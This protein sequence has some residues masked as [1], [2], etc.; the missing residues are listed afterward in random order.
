[1]KKFVNTFTAII[2]LIISNLPTTL[3]ADEIYTYNVTTNLSEISVTETERGAIY[4]FEPDN[5]TD[6]SGAPEIPFKIIRLALPPNTKISS[7]TANG[8]RIN[9]IAHNLDYAWNEGEMKT[10]IDATYDPAPK[11]MAIYNSS[12][13]YP[14]KYIELLNYGVMGAQPL[15]CFAIYPIQYRPIDGELMMVG[16]INI[17]I[18]LNS[19]LL[20][21][22]GP[23]PEAINIV[24]Q[25]VNNPEG[26][27]IQAPSLTSGDGTIPGGTIMGIGAEYLIITSGELAPAFYPFAVWKNQKGLLTEIVLIE[28]VLARYSGEDDAA[29]LREYLKEAHLAGAKW[30]LLGGDEDIIPI[31]Y[32]YPGNVNSAPELKNQQVSDLYFADL[33]GNWDVDGDGT[34]GEYVH[35]QPDIYPEVYVGR[36][37]AVS[38][39]EV[40]IWVNKA[41]MYEQNP[42]N[43]DYDYL[44]RGLFIINDQMRDLNQH[45]ELAGL[46]PDNFYVDNSSCAEEP[47]GG[48][49]EPTQPSGE[50]IV[51]AM[52]QGWGYISNHNHGGFYYYAARTPG[53]NNS[54]RSDMYGDTI[55]YTEQAGA[56]SHLDESNKYGVHY[57]ISCYN[58]AY[59]FDKEVFWPGPFIT[60]NSFMEAFLFLPEKGGV[61]YLGNTRWG[62]VSSSS[63]LEKKFVEYVFSDTAR[64]LAVA[65]TLSK[66]YYPTK[67]DLGYG[68][69]L[70][71]DPEMRIWA[72]APIL[73]NSSVPEHISLDSTS[74]TVEVSTAGG[75]AANIN[76]TAWK[77]GEMYLKGTTDGSGQLLIPLD[78]TETGY[79]Y[80]TAVGQNYLPHVDTIMVHLQ[81]SINDDGNPSLPLQ[82]GLYAN[83]PN[84]FNATTNISFSLANDGQ[85]QL[86][87]FDITGRL[88][89][90]LIDGNQPAGTHS[91][92]WDGLN[93]LDKVAASGTYFYRL[94]TDNE[95]FVKKMALLK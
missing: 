89:K 9:S 64:Q 1:M 94:K 36:I 42:N 77:P 80:I 86:Q 47:S 53:Y 4:Y 91:V 95:S 5:Y 60:N 17:E 88:V 62:W 12:D 58:A 66:L 74:I 57:S 41:L 93:D 37:P 52:N 48:A 8:S 44:T 43:G 68:H 35:D 24:R 34:Y 3:L 11:D 10:D 25:M 82:T 72:D 21:Q 39:E 7:V 59:D 81:S 55:R 83:Y 6:I 32:A 56:L 87:I 67:R 2:L 63:L 23:L 19:N 71:G 28:D 27:S 69:T 46:M 16:E 31:R 85:V 76:V 30:V 75:P 22:S 61:A 29:R 51:A 45:I 73:L 49:L 54:P 18:H 20:P 13:L 90:T 40:E 15:A 50:Q 33:N 78:L 14:G 92:I 38:P 84:P 79:L 70:F 65:E 26:I